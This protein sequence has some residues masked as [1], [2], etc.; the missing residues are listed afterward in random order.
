MQTAPL[1]FGLF[2]LGFGSVACGAQSNGHDAAASGGKGQGGAGGL[3][4]SSGLGGAGG[5][6]SAGMGGMPLVCPDPNATVDPTAMIDDFEDGDGLVLVVDGR[7]GGWWTA[8]DATGGTLVPAQTSLT[9]MPPTPERLAEPRCGSHY[10]MRI[11]G[12]GFTDWGAILGVGLAYG[13]RPNGQ[14]GTVPYDASARTGVDFWARVGDT[15]TNNVFFEVTDSNSEPDGGVCDV[16]GG[17][18][19]ECYDHFGV[20]LTNLD[21]S[22]HHYHI[23]FSGLSQRNFGVKAD[24]VVTSAV[25][26]LAFAFLSATDPFDFWVDDISFY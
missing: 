11:T 1:L 9:N 16:N 8:A 20:N 23:P 21:T 5:L 4:T 3:G 26:N 25:Y 19:T 12:E 14:P 10:A 15:S 22:W 24:G 13:T 7:N 2:L 18:G 6:A 17:I